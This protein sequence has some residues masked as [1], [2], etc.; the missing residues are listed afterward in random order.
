[1]NT[2][3]PYAVLTQ[4]Q[5]AQLLMAAGKCGLFD[6]FA[7]SQQLSEAALLAATGLPTRS[8]SALL[9]ALVACGFLQR[10]EDQG[11]AQ[12]S[13]NAF[14]APFARTGAGGLARILHKEALF[15]GIWDRM[16]DALTSGSSVL[17][18]LYQR[19]DTQPERVL[20]FLFALNDIAATAAP[21]IFPHLTGLASGSLLDLGCGGGGYTR[22]FLQRFPALNITAVDLPPVLEIA[23]EHCHDFADAGRLRW[24]AGDFIREQGLLAG[25]TFDAVWLSHVLHDYP[26]QQL[27]AILHA[28]SRLT[29][30]GG[31][32]WILDVFQDTHAQYPTEALFDLMMLVENPGGATHPAATVIDYAQACGLQFCAQH[33]LYFGGLLEFKR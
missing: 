25:E 5:E 33:K 21:G 12:Y 14:S 10:S 15:Y 23:Q 8:L 31:R 17:P 32:L 13:L 9:R 20:T 16:A 3:D 2:K 4:Y 1:M 7:G 18:D 24:V 19:L 27:P 26:E 6:A 30:T 29:R 28:C 11:V 22:E